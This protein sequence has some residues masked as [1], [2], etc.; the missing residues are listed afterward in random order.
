MFEKLRQILFRNKINP[1]FT[2]E[3]REVILTDSNL[4]NSYKENMELINGI[5]SEYGTFLHVKKN[6]LMALQKNLVVVYH[7]LIK[8]RDFKDILTSRELKPQELLFL[9]NNQNRLAIEDL[10]RYQELSELD[11]ASL[12][13]YFNYAEN[14]KKLPPAIFDNKYYPYIKEKYP[15]L[16]DYIANLNNY[17]DADK[18]IAK[19]TSLLANGSID[20]FCAIAL[21]KN[22]RKIDFDCNFAIFDNKYFEALPLDLI[23]AIDFNNQKEIEEI[24]K[25][26]DANK[27][28]FVKDYL[29]CKKAGILTSDFNAELNTITDILSNFNNNYQALLLYKVFGTAKMSEMMQQI[30]KGYVSL[31]K[32]D[33]TLIAKYEPL[34]NFITTIN[35]CNSIE[36]FQKLN[37]I[38]ENKNIDYSNYL[39]NMEQ[40]IYHHNSELICESLK[41]IIPYEQ[42]FREEKGAKIVDLNG[43]DFTMLLH[44]VYNH[45]RDSDEET[46]QKRFSDF[47]GSIS[48][49]LISDHN[50]HFYDPFNH[51]LAYLG[52]Y[53]INPSQIA[54]AKEKDAGA[55]NFYQTQNSEVK[56]PEQ[57]FDEASSYNEVVL[58]TNGGQ[59]MPDYIVCFNNV[60]NNSMDIAK[61]YNI[62]IYVIHTLNY[63]EASIDSPL[64]NQQYS[65]ISRGYI[66]Y[67]YIFLIILTIFIGITI[68]KILVS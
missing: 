17:N 59:Q 38:I 64:L 23:L 54:K 5:I 14:R 20:N 26:L 7:E 46:L 13:N 16:L 45:G 30:I 27:T 57:I 8:K 18:K 66:N 12:Q 36:A 28:S 48:C 2:E 31:D 58:N 4:R 11:E 39:S 33:S 43:Q 37:K 44:A 61:T 50:I 29:M 63:P 49:S 6:L 21:N 35:R 51:A 52:Y 68:A 47:N 19:I 25:A 67:V 60:D 1:I 15:K 34:I 53:N 56:L 32:L 65:N 10:K 40:D 24:I 22:Y 3:E 41:Q 9:H 55:N 42:N 62:P